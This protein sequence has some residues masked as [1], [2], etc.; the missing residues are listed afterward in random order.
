MP[1]QIA[2]DPETGHEY[3]WDDVVAFDD[4]VDEETRTQL[5]AAIRS[6]P[7]LAEA[8]F[9][10]SDK[11]MVGLPEIPPGGV[12]IRLL[13]EDHGKSFYRVAVT[14]RAGEQFDLAINLNRS[15]LGIRDRGGNRLADRLR[16]T[17]RRRRFGK[18]LRRLLGI[19]QTL[20]RGIHPW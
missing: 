7:L 16:R 17:E 2:V 5:L 20:D 19:P 12:W 14:T 6:T 4:D 8:G 1:S 10:F 13:G 15:A 3:R 9:L 18:E 11:T